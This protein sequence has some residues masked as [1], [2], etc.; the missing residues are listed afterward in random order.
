MEAV[1]TCWTKTLLHS[2]KTLKITIILKGGERDGAKYMIYITS[3][4]NCHLFSQYAK[5]LRTTRKI[6]YEVQSVLLDFIH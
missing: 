3:T 1:Q 5:Y 2:I 6:I 4:I